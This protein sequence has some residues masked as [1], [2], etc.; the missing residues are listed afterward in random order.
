MRVQEAY[1]LPLNDER[2]CALA[3]KCDHKSHSIVLEGR[4]RV[5]DGRGKMVWVWKTSR[6]SP[7]PVKLSRDVS[8]ILA[9]V[10]P[11]SAFLQRGEVAVSTEAFAE[12]VQCFAEG[13]SKSQRGQ[14]QLEA[15]TGDWPPAAAPVPPPPAREPRPWPVGAEQWGRH[16]C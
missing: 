3:R 16:V 6:A 9:E 2:M 14:L 13:C 10:A 8:E 4:V 1:H 11:R 5:R 15:A 12:V 7:Y